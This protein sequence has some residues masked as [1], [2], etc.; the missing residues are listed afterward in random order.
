MRRTA[1]AHGVVMAELGAVTARLTRL[2][3]DDMDEEELARRVC[4]ACVECLDVGG[5]AI[6]VLTAEASRRTLWATDEIAL[7]RRRQPAAGRGRPRHRDPAAR[8]SGAERGGRQ[9]RAPL[10]VPTTQPPRRASGGI[11]GPDV[12][13]VDRGARR[14]RASGRR[15]S[16]CGAASRC[17]GPR[18]WCGR[19]AGESAR[20]P[21]ARAAQ[22]W[23]S[24][25]LGVGIAC[26]PASGPSWMI[27]SRSRMA[28]SWSSGGLCGSM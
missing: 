15:R 27:R 11:R 26:R 23:I 7:N 13:A 4:E 6:S 8:P 9:R 16:R 3:A 12:L 22:P 10:T 14:C 25:R 5:A 24:W 17:R 2:V 28:H 1:G 21:A 19:A 20:Q 18:A